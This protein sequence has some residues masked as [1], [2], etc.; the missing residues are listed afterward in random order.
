MHNM[1]V[2]QSHIP[3]L[4]PSIC[5]L[6]LP[7]QAHMLS[8]FEFA[9]HYHIKQAKHPITEGGHAAQQVDNEAYH[10]ALTDNGIDKITKGIKNL[11]PNLDYQIREEGGVDW[12]P[13]GCGEYG[14][15]YRHD[16]V[17][18]ARKRPY[19]PVLYGA[20]GSRTK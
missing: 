13:L 16:W 7:C 11:A 10:A 5:S 17:M 18:V 1:F 6:P 12:L 20:Q 14:Q 9:R 15:Q 8:A 19:V 3:Q 2:F 4:I